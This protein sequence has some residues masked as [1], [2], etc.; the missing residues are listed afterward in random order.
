MSMQPDI[1]RKKEGFQGQKAIV[2]PRKI[3]SQQ[4]SNNPVISGLYIT[5][6]GYYPKAKFHYRER[7]HGAEQNILIHCIEGRGEVSIKKTAY[8][9]E[10]GDFFFVPLKTAH[11]YA[12]DEK[13]PWT[14]Y[15]LHFKG[16]NADAVISL[17]N[18]LY[19]GH[20]GF[21]P[22]NE[23]SVGLFNEMYNQLERGYSNEYL[24]YSNMCLWHYL[25]IFTYNNNANDGEKNAAK[26]CTNLA[27][28]FL[29]KNLDRVLTIEEIANA[30]NLSSSHFSYIFKTKTGYS[31]IEYFNHLK[32]QKACQYLL[33]TDL[34]IKEI[35]AELGI[36]DPHY[37]SRMFTKIMGSSPMGYREKRIQ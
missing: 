24:N 17:M 21:L 36:E 29:S 3:L 6:I 7:Q 18:R 15:W 13:N 9:I 20:K 8:K 32:V 34:R 22:V 5:D 1:V 31:P 4:C 30:V 2:I 19:N 26:D 37:F 35:S 25:S 12:A 23:K 28:D 14:I 10:P 33:F 27:I 11:K 16:V